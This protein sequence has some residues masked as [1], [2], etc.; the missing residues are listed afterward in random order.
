MAETS[1]FRPGWDVGIPDIGASA[2]SNAANAISQNISSAGKDIGANLKQNSA[3]DGLLKTFSTMKDPNTGKPMIDPET[4]GSISKQSLPAKQQ[5]IGM[6]SASAAQQMQQN[7]ELQGQKN[8]L[9]YFSG[10]PQAL[11]TKMGLA[12]PNPMARPVPTTS[13]TPGSQP[14]PQQVN[15]QQ[16]QPQNPGQFQ[17]PQA[18]AQN[19]SPLRPGWAHGLVKDAKG[20]TT[21]SMFVGPNGEQIPVAH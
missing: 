3:T 8:L 21:G 2:I 15:P 1:Q 9:G 12:Q 20:N 5:F 19:M 14:M 17:G 4:M 7:N 11:Q 16:A 13:A 10:N 18:G 6:L